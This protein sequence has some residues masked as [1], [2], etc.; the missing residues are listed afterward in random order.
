M[1]DPYATIIQRLGNAYGQGFFMNGACLCLA[2][3]L[4]EAA[5]DAGHPAS[6]KLILEEGL[7]LHHALVEITI[8]GRTYQNS[9]KAPSFR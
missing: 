5:E 3:I 4:L 6:L 7:F 9:R 8:D 2:S 1:P